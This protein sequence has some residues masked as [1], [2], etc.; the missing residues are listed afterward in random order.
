MVRAFLALGLA[1][2]LCTWTGRSVMR[3]KSAAALM[4]LAG[5]LLVTVVVLTHVCEALGT[6][7]FM[8]WGSPH[9]AGHYL[10]L[11]SAV[12][13]AALFTLGAVIR[14]AREFRSRRH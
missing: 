9:S 4:Q 10:D 6:F 7:P 3:E 12:A 8:H 13:G 2:A 1:V 5:S 14:R 11:S